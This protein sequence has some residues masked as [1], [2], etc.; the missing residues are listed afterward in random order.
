MIAIDELK[1]DQIAD[2]GSM[3]GDEDDGVNGSQKST[4]RR[5]VLTKPLQIG[6]ARPGVVGRRRR[7]TRVSLGGGKR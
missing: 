1:V 6:D 2:A 4:C 5:L 3:V 7:R